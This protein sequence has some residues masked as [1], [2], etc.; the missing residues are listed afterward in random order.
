M[1]IHVVAGV[2]GSLALLHAV[3]QQARACGL[4]PGAV[5]ADPHEG[6]DDDPAGPVHRDRVRQIV[7]PVP[8][9][10]AGKQVVRRHRARDCHGVPGDVQRTHRCVADVGVADRG[11]LHEQVDVVGPHA[12]Q[13]RYE[14]PSA[15][16]RAV[17]EL[18]VIADANVVLP[19]QRAGA[20]HARNVQ[21]RAGG[22]DHLPVV[23]ADV[24]PARV[25]LRCGDGAVH[26]H[27]AVEHHARRR[28]RAAVPVARHVAHGHHVADDQVVVVRRRAGLAQLGPDRVARG[29]VAPCT[30]RTRHQRAAQA[31]GQRLAASVD[32]HGAPDV[33]VVVQVDAVGIDAERDVRRVWRVGQTGGVGGRV[34]DG[35]L[36]SRDDERRCAA[37]VRVLGRRQ[38]DAGH[39][40]ARLHLERPLRRQTGDAVGRDGHLFFQ[41][42]AAGLAVLVVVAKTGFKLRDLA[43]LREVDLGGGELHLAD[44][45]LSA[46]H[47]GRDQLDFVGQRAVGVLQDGFDA[48]DG[49]AA[50][51]RFLRDA[52]QQFFPNLARQVVEA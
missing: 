46:L 9:P 22:E 40:L 25:D 29:G 11:G 24:Q 15:H 13:P 36:L 37:A 4:P 42:R 3:D 27:V 7:P 28:P 14:V 48:A 10:R 39:V 2:D 43:R 44:A 45:R 21:P 51:G 32:A 52:A 23:V 16:R 49:R 5:G 1:N 34:D 12:G 33:H 35:E 38:A 19:R 20:C 18:H 47:G 30:I 6:Q 41:Q 31:V 8:Q 26:Q 17:G 50:L